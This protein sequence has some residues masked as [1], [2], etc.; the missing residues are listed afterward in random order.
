LG[1]T[2]AYLQLNVLTDGILGNSAWTALTAGSFLNPNTPTR[3]DGTSSLTLNEIMNWKGDSGN[4]SAAFGSSVGTGVLD[5]MGQNLKDNWFEMAIKSTL[6]GVGF[7]MGKKILRK[8][9]SSGQKVLNMAGL[10]GAVSIR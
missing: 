2:E 1:L 9:L 4:V 8:P 5:V 7:R 6:I 3:G 10:K